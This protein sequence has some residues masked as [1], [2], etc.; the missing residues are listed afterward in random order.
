[1]TFR[2]IS[3]PDSVV[4]R[5]VDALTSKELTSTLKWDRVSEE[6]ILAKAF[7]FDYYTFRVDGYE[8]T[9][10]AWLTQRTGYETKYGIDLLVT[11][12]LK[13]KQSG[14]GLTK[15]F[16]AQAKKCRCKLVCRLCAAILCALL[17]ASGRW[18]CPVD[19]CDGNLRDKA[20][21]QLR[22][23]LQVT[24]E[25]SYLLILTRD[26]G[27]YYARAI[28]L[29]DVPGLSCEKVSGRAIC[30]PLFYFM[31]A[32]CY[33]GEVLVDEYIRDAAEAFHYYMRRAGERAERAEL[34]VEDVTPRL[35]AHLAVEGELEEA[36]KE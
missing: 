11:M 16:I 12:S 33:V 17:C 32:R 1:M 25:H 28:D 8:V 24:E 7:D 5:I 13:D 29:V 2:A 6:T 26:H 22:K 21:E 10:D 31:F 9:I 35:H 34:E 30:S 18:P 3:L 15:F 23:M 36:W 4:C 27:F 20:R 14:A 19:F